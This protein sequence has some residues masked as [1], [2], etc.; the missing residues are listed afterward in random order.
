MQGSVQVDKFSRTALALYWVFSTDLEIVKSVSG[1][2]NVFAENFLRKEDWVKNAWLCTEMF[3]M[4][5]ICSK[6]QSCLCIPAE[7]IM[8][9]LQ[10]LIYVLC[11]TNNSQK[12]F[13]VQFCKY[14]KT[15]KT[16]C[17]IKFFPGTRFASATTI[18]TSD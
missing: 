9:M 4:I 15:K 11:K 17:E 1:N 8:G 18:S 10:K 12:N 13:V 16:F 7:K 3:L 5:G 2:Q 6:K 14:L